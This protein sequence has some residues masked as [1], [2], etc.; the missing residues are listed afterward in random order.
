[1]ECESRSDIGKNRG[2]WNHLKIHS[3]RYLSNTEEKHDAKEP[4]KKPHCT[5]TAG[6]ANVKVQNTVNMPNNITCSTD[7]KY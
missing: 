4:Q 2:D 3:R 7:C 6:N 1:V 5:L